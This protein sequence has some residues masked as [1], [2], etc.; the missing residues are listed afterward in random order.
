[1]NNQL[2]QVDDQ[3]LVNTAC[4]LLLG[5]SLL[6]SRGRRE[7][8]GW[9]W[10]WGTPAGYKNISL[11]QQVPTHNQN[12]CFRFP[13]FIYIFWIKMNYNLI[14]LFTVAFQLK[15]HPLYSFTTLRIIISRLN[16][17]FVVII[18]F[19]YKIRMIY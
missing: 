6:K 5:V 8:G 14:I 2:V 4:N 1:M 13:S 16:C 17:N 11:Q 15:D 19:S 12:N 7:T 3:V 10:G 18:L 9:G